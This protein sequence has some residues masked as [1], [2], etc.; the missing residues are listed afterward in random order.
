M[1]NAI[2]SAG[3]RVVC[4]N[5]R[6]PGQIWEWTDE[7]PRSGHVYTVAEVKNVRHAITGAASRAYVLKELIP[8]RVGDT[9]TGISFCASR[10]RSLRFEY[11]AFGMNYIGVLARVGARRS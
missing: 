2:A 4:I 6:F 8:Y 1:N 5:D 3:D 7:I 11:Y 9:W 10:F